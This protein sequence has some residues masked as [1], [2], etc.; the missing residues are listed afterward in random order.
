MKVLKQAIGARKGSRR[1]KSGMETS[2]AGW[3]QN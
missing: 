3:L 1:E 2:R